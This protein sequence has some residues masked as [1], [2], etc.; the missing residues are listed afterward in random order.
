[1]TIV[2]EA[3]VALRPDL[4]GFDATAKAQTEAALAGSQVEGQ[5][6][7]SAIDQG[8]ASGVTGLPSTKKE[9]DAAMTD[10]ASKTEAAGEQAGAKLESGMT[11]G[12]GGLGSLLSSI[13]LPLGDLGNK[14]DD[15]GKK[16]TSAGSGGG[17]FASMLG[18]IPVPAA[19][20]AGAVIAVGAV[21]VDMGMKFQDA[22]ARLASAAGISVDAANQ[23]GNA[24]LNTMGTTIYSGTAIT[25]AYAAVAAQL[26]AVQGK[27]LDSAQAMSVMRA[28][29]DLAEASGVSLTSASS[30]LAGV[31]QAF[32]IQA[33]GA[34]QAADEL[35]QAGRLSGNGIDAVSAAVKQMHTQLGALTPSLGQTGALIVDLANHGETGSKAIRSVSTAMVTMLKGSDTL[36]NSQTALNAATAALPPSLR[37]LAAGYSAGTLTQAQI[38]AGTKDLTLSQKD[39]WDAF[40]KSSAAV[41]TAGDKY[42][43]LGI[44]VINSKGQFVGIKSV[45]EQLGPALQGM[46][47]AQQMAALQQVFGAS[48]STKL[49]DTILA[50]P[51]AYAKATAEVEKHGAAAAGAAKQSQTLSHQM[52]L[53]K[54]TASDVGTKLGVVLIPMIEKI[55][56]AVSKVVGFLAAHAN[57]VK[58]FFEVLFTVMTGG[59]AIVLLFHDQIIHAFEDIWHFIDD[60]WQKVR[61]TT[62]TV[63]NDIV[64]FFT[65]IPTKIMGAL[66]SLGGLLGGWISSAWTYVTTG[67]A[68]AWSAT[69]GWFSGLWSRI[70]TAVGDIAGKF[71]SWAETA[72]QSVLTGYQVVWGT[73]AGWLADLWNKVVTAVGDIAGKFLT[74]ASTA[75]TAVLTGYQA[76]WGTI[77]AWLGDLWNKIVTAATD[78]GSK[79]LS[80]AESAF[81]NI[82]TGFQVG[83][84]TMTGWLGNL[85]TYITG[86]IGDLAHFA[87]QL[88]LDII[89]G[90]RNGLE[91]G[92]ATLLRTITS[93]GSDIVNAFKSAISAFSPSRRFAEEGGLP[94]MQGIAL[95][96]TNNA[97]LPIAAIQAVAAKLGQ[98]PFSINPISVAGGLPGVGGTAGTGTS[99]LVNALQ[100]LVTETRTN[101]SAIRQQTAQ[102][103]Q[104]TQVQISGT[105]PNSSTPLGSVHALAIGLSK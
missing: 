83:F 12:I 69:A 64:S 91:A 5:K 77:A 67:L 27:A 44:S 31:M 94:I 88:G 30:A 50:G 74:W 72:F 19:L 20:A 102:A 13:G 68:T 80:W 46:T 17:S 25:Q 33:S 89:D 49:L 8:L 65:S 23:I 71:L 103:Q 41:A 70:T 14:A 93:I 29:M 4:T 85:W 10:V 3:F 96:I 21:A 6:A 28:A 39:A 15:A 45:I 97:H 101:T 66:S 16:L 63:W 61:S 24:F 35:Y 57:D 52:D 99:D 55:L 56:S 62:L 48:A 84:L 81:G 1:M 40:T 26:S 100:S 53:M 82:L 76:V 105:A 32:G 11:K 92:L 60:A 37:D 2:G 51:S 47:Q 22:T 34:A 9:V 73:I 75:F 38:T 104:P 43:A 78:I 7:G 42:A 90:I 36:I 86:A 59:T 79:F 87:W 18:A 54:A 58:I 98:V 95:G